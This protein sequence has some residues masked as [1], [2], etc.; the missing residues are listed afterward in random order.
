[1][2]Y[3]VYFEVVDA[4]YIIIIIYILIKENFIS[5]PNFYH[6]SYKK[7]AQGTVL[8]TKKETVNIQKTAISC[9]MK[10]IDHNFKCDIRPYIRGVIYLFWPFAFKIRF[11]LS[12][13]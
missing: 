2:S 3:L 4:I 6:M 9:L 12:V 11:M 8:T 5:P 10:L 1:M 7:N 13:A